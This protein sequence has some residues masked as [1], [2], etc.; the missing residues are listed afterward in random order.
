MIESVNSSSK[1]DAL[2]MFQAQNAFA[3][4]Q[5]FKNSQEK[6]EN[7][8]FVEVVASDEILQKVDVSELKHLASQFQEEITDE[9]IKYGLVY[10]R[11]VIADY[12]A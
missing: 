5:T 1:I 11:S 9:E 2:K 4:T 12:T 7:E 8:N 3:K 10:G 6:L